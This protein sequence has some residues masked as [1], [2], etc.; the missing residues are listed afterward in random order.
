MNSLS[1]ATIERKVRDIPQSPAL[2]EDRTVSLGWKP[3]A[4]DQ[5]ESEWWDLLIAL[6]SNDDGE[7]TVALATTLRR[8][9]QLG[10]QL[11]AAPD[12]ERSPTPKIRLTAGRMPEA[13]L[14]AGASTPPDAP[15]REGRP[16]AT[17]GGIRRDGSADQGSDRV[18]SASRGGGHLATRIEPDVPC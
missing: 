13:G 11:V 17:G 1:T 10:A 9:R 7:A 2:L 18:R 14:P 6:A 4:S 5:S 12:T 15:R 8:L 16:P 3:H